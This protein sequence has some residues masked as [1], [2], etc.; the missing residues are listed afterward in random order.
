MPFGSKKLLALAIA[1]AHDVTMLDT[2][3][4]EALIKAIALMERKW[5][6]ETVCRPN[7]NIERLTRPYWDWEVKGLRQWRRIHAYLLRELVSSR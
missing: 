7:G 5:G 4:K 2:E 6:R 1:S 3:R